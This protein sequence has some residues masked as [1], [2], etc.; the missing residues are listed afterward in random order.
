M[1]TLSVSM[2]CGVAGALGLAEAGIRKSYD[3]LLLLWLEL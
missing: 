2:T 1:Y 3:S